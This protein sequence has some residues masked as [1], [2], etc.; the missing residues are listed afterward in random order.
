M[1]FKTRT[2]ERAAHVNR[3]QINPHGPFLPAD[4]TRHRPCPS[5]KQPRVL[6]VSICFE[7]NSDQ[8]SRNLNNKTLYN[9]VFLWH[10][11]LDTVKRKATSRRARCGNPAEPESSW[12]SVGSDPAPWAWGRLEAGGAHVLTAAFAD[13]RVHLST[14]WGL[15]ANPC[16]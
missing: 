8:E 13:W 15:R 4:S 12:A 9:K 14:C 6:H 2:L 1:T 16:S 5:I 10:T 11:A 3:K 7:N